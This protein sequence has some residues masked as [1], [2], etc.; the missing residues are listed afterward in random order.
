LSLAG[1]QSGARRGDPQRQLQ[2]TQ[3]LIPGLTAA[4]AILNALEG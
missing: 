3:W 4:I 2:V 1:I